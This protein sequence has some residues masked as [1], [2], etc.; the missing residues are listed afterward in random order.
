MVRTFPGPG[1]LW[2]EDG[3]VWLW[4]SLVNLCI[5]PTVLSCYCS[6]PLA[7]ELFWP[8]GGLSTLCDSCGFPGQQRMLKTF[9]GSSYLPSENGIIWLCHWLVNLYIWLIILS[10]YGSI[11]LALGLIQSDGGFITIC[12][13]CEF[14]SQNVV[15]KNFLALVILTPWLSP[16]R[17]WGSLNMTF[18]GKFVHMAQHFI[19]L[20]LNQFELRADREGGWFDDSVS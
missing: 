17:A 9:S 13:S 5:W 3:A 6:I 12:R 10:C 4:H 8:N 19:L 16:R 15:L 11:P 18:T 2:S 7:L 20:R 1:Y 14:V